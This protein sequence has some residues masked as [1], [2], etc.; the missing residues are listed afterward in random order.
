MNKVIK[1]LLIAVLAL[2]I[3]GAISYFSFMNAP[4]ASSKGKKIELSIPAAELFKAFEQDETAS[5]A[6][7]MSKIIAVT[8]II[9]E[10]EEDRNGAPVLFLQTGADVAGIL[11]TLE[12]S[13]KE[14]ASGLKT[15]DAVTVKGVCT[16][17]LM[18][19]VINKGI[20]IDK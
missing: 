11:C 9:D 4:K 5:N 8:G 19:V 13:Q 16:G 20:L 1:V 12:S 17:M 7:Y 15:G 3:I 2:G 18:E 14:K 10:I 6:K